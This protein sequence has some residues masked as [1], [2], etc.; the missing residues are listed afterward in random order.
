MCL[1][2]RCLQYPDDAPSTVKKRKNKLH[3][4]TRLYYL[5]MSSPLTTRLCKADV[6]T[7]G[8]TLYIVMRRT[9]DLG[10][11]YVLINS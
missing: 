7:P 3:G 1:S 4:L 8:K 2:L 5:T 9:L 6:E 11:P 10:L